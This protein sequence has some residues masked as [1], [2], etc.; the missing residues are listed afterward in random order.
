MLVNS[1]TCQ[2]SHQL[3]SSTN[4]M[5]PNQT[6]H[7]VHQPSLQP[8]IQASQGKRRTGINLYNPIKSAVG[9]VCLLIHPRYLTRGS[10]RG[11]DN[12]YFFHQR[13]NLRGSTRLFIIFCV[14]F[15]IHFFCHHPGLFI[16]YSAN[17]GMPPD[18]LISGV[19]HNTRKI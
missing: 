18:N 12:I 6:N 14:L 11:Y 17:G 16:F 2:K 3:I 9:N 7:S 15:F 10:L 4:Q 13:A 19:I 5:S 8:P 1:T